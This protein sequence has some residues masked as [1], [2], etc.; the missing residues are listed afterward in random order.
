MLSTP[1]YSVLFT[2]AITDFVDFYLWLPSSSTTW[3]ILWT[4]IFFAATPGKS[5]RPMALFF[6]FHEFIYWVQTYTA[7]KCL[8]WTSTSSI[9]RLCHTNKSRYIL[10][11]FNFKYKK[12]HNSRSRGVAFCE[13][14]QTRT[15]A[16][17]NTFLKKH[18]K[19]RPFFS[20]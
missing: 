3:Y 14:V 6:A 17:S 15:L 2:L 10:S 1:V 20:Q 8:T 19:V 13:C 4:D 16:H 9:E 11:S 7:Q 12:E 18:V 5:F